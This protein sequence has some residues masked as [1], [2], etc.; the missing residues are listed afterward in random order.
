MSI[1]ADFFKGKV[2][3]YHNLNVY[4]YVFKPINQQIESEKENWL[5]KRL[6]EDEYERF[7]KLEDLY[8]EKI[9]LWQQKIFN[10][11]FKL[12]SLLML[13]ILTGNEDLFKGSGN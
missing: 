7:E 3:P 5:K 13:E 4:D 11:S 12:G 1:L 6:S 9:N 8:Y 10:Y 2:S